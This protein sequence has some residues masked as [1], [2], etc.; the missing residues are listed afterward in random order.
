MSAQMKKEKKKQ[1]EIESK[2]S[3]TLKLLG[4]I[5]TQMMKLKKKMK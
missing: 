4:I 1:E 5:T 3:T 2:I